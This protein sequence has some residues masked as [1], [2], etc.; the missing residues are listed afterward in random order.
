MDKRIPITL[1]T[2]YLGSGK[3]TLLN[4]VLEN[5]EGYKVA[6]IVNDIG[7]VNIDAE[8]IQRG[9]EVTLEDDNLVALSNGC[10]CCSLKT[11][12][13]KQIVN[14]VKQGRF[15]YILIEA[16]GICE[17]LSIVQTIAMLDG[18]VEDDRLPNICRLDNVVSVVDARRLVD[19][20]VSGKSL[21][22]EDIGEDDIESLIIQQI[23]FCNTIILN[24]VSDITKEEK[25]EVLAVVRKLQP[26]A[27]I[28]E[29]DYAKAA[30]SDILN[31]EKFDL[32]SVENSSGWKKVFLEEDAA[33][34][35]HEEEHKKHSHTDSHNHDDNDEHAH[36]HEHRHH[37]HHHDGDKDEYG[38]GTFLYYTRRPFQYE[39]FEN[40]LNNKWPA[41][42]IRSKGMVWFSDEWDMA[43]IFEQAGRQMNLTPAGLWAAAASKEQ[44]EEAMK[45]YPSIK[46]NWDK[47]Y[48]DRM[49]KLVFI[50]KNMDKD[51]ITRELDACLDN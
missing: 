11:D 49:V 22:A 8:L 4:H 14:L 23:E 24:K 29:T 15:D 36:G 17:P 28:I 47:K 38:I 48:G 32:G 1:I 26:E 20:F 41:N 39:K 7:E 27:E 42:V 13:M 51:K 6:V 19:E 30:V 2:G 50:G 33:S 10:I 16:S 46:E 45:N 12:L 43:Q 31:T 35:H 34:E 5:Q 25:A 40:W 18:T 21:I 37:H 9:G 3:T 44:Q